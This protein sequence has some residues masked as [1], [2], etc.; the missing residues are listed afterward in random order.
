MQ[1]NQITHALGMAFILVVSSQPSGYRRA[2]L[3]LENGENKLP[4]EQI[5]TEQLETLE[6][7]PR[8]AVSLI[9]QASEETTSTPNVVTGN[10]CT[11]VDG[12]EL[13]LEGVDEALHPF[14]GVMAIEQFE[15]KPTVEQL[16]ISI[17]DT[18]NGEKV[19]GELKPTAAQRDAAWNVYQAAIKT[20]SEQ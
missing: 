18:E 10:I 9:A 3:R 6:A 7:D 13:D 12:I 16:A 15:K 1:K 11:T 17:S 19:T 5:T 4:A 14:I 2:G 20:Q 8:L